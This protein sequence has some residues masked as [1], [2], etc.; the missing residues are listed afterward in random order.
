MKVTCPKDQHTFDI[1]IKT[2]V[3]WVVGS[4]KLRSACQS[5]LAR[6]YR[7]KAK[8]HNMARTSEQASAAAKIRWEKEASR[9][10]NRTDLPQPI[11][12]QQKNNA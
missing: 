10:Q 7:T 11:K 4:D 12:P 5:A 2:I 8:P 9:I 3:D 6:Y 1:P